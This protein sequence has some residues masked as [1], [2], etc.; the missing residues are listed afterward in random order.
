[1][2]VNRPVGAAYPS[3]LGQ[4]RPMNAPPTPYTQAPG[5]PYT[6]STAG[7]SVTANLKAL[8]QTLWAAAK[9]LFARFMQGLSEIR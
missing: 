6:T 3:L 9:D 1:M 2:F 5:S 8:G 7:P 4:T